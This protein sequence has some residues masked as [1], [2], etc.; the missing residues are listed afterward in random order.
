MRRIALVVAGALASMLLA[1]AGVEAQTPTASPATTATPSVTP[2]ATPAIT[3]TARIGGTITSGTLGLAVPEGLTVQLIV[4]D[5]S[6][7]GAPLTAPV[8]GGAYVVEVPLAAGRVFIP[9]LVSEG[10]EY[11]GDPVTFPD[12]APRT[13][14]RD[15]RV[16]GVTREAPQ[17]AIASSTITVIGIDREQGQLGLVRED[18]V[19]NPSDRVFIGDAQGVTLRI[20]APTGTI[21]ATGE[22]VDGTF[23]FERGVVTTTVPIRP[24][25]L[26]SIVTR[27]VVGYDTQADQYALRATVPLA[28]ESVVVRVPE[29]FVGA[30]KPQAGARRGTDVPASTQG[31]PTGRPGAGDTQMLQIVESE[32]PVKPGGGIVV[33]L[34]GL[35]K[36]VIQ[37]NP[38]TERTGALIAAAL[39]IAI[40]GGA[41]A[42]RWRWSRRPA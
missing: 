15:F 5:G 8:S 16:Y 41:T 7:V 35:S 33:N 25:R 38:L 9:R 3:G 32:G 28:A 39:A 18:M 42:A 6:A 29:G 24:G 31:A 26:T 11:L 17:L 14:T 2:N 20:P 10:V 30:V 12:G 22:N 23:A 40:V 27:Y 13:A 34:V 4:L 19:A 36:A 37:S 21:E 1:S